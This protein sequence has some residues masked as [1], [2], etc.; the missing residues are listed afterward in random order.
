ME[1]ITKEEYDAAGAALFLL[2]LHTLMQEEGC[3]SVVEAIRRMRASKEFACVL[4]DTA[5]HF[6]SLYILEQR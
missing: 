2:Y 3:G 4:V 6:D 5:I 1:G